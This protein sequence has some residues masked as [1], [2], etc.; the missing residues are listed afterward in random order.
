LVVSIIEDW[1]QAECQYFA[2]VTAGLERLAWQDIER[3]CETRLVG[4]GH[5]RIDFTFDGSPAELLGLR[6]VDDVYVYVA[7]LTG[8]DHTRAS[9]ARLT[10]KIAPAD[11]LP[12]LE[13][14][15]AVRPISVTPTYRVTASHLGRRNYSRYDVEGAVEAAL[16]GNLPWRF[17]LNDADEQEPEIDLRVLLEDD[18]ALLGLRLGSA[19]LHRRA[20]K[21][22]SRPGSL[23]PPVAYCL[24]LLAELRPAAVV[25]DPACGAGTILVEVAALAAFGVICGGDI[26]PS[27]LGSAHANLEASGLDA[28]LI[29]LSPGFDPRRPGVPAPAGGLSGIAEDARKPRVLLYQGDATDLPLADRTIDAVI[30]NLPWGQQVT[31]G[32]DLSPLYEGMLATIERVLVPGGCAVLLTDQ[33]EQLLAALEACP[34]LRLASSLQ[35]SLYGR[36]PTIYVLDTTGE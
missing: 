26:D 9:L 7:R 12:A 34:R 23:K 5:R 29:R 30:S 13:V 4:F 19:P 36:H 22:A 24:G 25:L 6:C 17:V 14:C 35:I 27:A 33:S 3:R 8:L 11:L 18:W 21:V 1:V 20:Y 28:E 10:Q 2:R 31:A 32:T 15:A 16:A